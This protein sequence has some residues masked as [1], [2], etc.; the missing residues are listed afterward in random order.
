MILKKRVKA[1]M[2]KIMRKKIRRITIKINLFRLSK[3]NPRDNK[4]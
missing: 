3:D 4:A 1:L 2:S